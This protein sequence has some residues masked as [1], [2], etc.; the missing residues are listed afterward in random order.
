MLGPLPPLHRAIVSACAL[1]AFV[2]FGAW[3]G[4]S[5][6]TPAVM[7]VGAGIGA[8][9]GVVAVLLLLHEANP[10][11]PRAQRLRARHPRHH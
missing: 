11:Q 8:G 1:L 10:R 2:G 6:P 9:L 3:V 7:S 5:L 4:F